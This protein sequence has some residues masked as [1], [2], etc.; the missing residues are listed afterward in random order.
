MPK[1]SGIVRN[2]FRVRTDDIGKAERTADGIVFDSKKE[3]RHY[4]T[5]KLLEKSKKI[6]ALQLQPVF[7]I[8]VNGQLICKY[9]ADFQY[10]DHSDLQVHTV[11]CKGM[12]TDVYRLK[13][14]LLKATWDI[15]IEE[16]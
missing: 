4:G 10:L 12:K 8:E 5:L 16:V 3:A 14:K 6:S 13:K 11:D 7:R 1:K 9:I 15:D 2:K